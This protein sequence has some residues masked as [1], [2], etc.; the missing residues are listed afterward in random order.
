MAS[1]T[2]NDRTAMSESQEDYLEAIRALIGEHGHAHTRD[3]ALRL[4]VK[5]PSV[6][7]ALRMLA[8]RELI[9]Y[10]K[11]HPIQLTEAGRRVADEVQGRHS[12]LEGFFRD[13]LG[14]PEGKA[15]ETACRVEHCVD[16]ETIARWEAYAAGKGAGAPG[17]G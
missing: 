7:R 9:Q 4:G 14:L 5:M 2:P 11:N 3:I 17:R 16:A 12:F 1:M 8:Q 13:A 10:R 6:T 15:A